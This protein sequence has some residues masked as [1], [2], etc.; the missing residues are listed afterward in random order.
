MEKSAKLRIIN[1]RVVGGDGGSIG[2]NGRFSIGG[3]GGDC[4]A[5]IVFPSRQFKIKDVFG[6]SL[7]W[8]GSH[9]VIN[10]ICQ[11]WA[12]PAGHFLANLIALILWQFKGDLPVS[13]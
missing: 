5:S 11:E 7:S 6:R 1:K 8:R 12:T 9:Q 4:K 13:K 10:P 2:C 3:V